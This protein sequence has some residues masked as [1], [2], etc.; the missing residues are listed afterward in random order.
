MTGPPN[1]TAS[2]LQ[3][4]A[5]IGAAAGLRYVYAGNLPGRV[6]DL[7]NTHCPQ[8]REVVVERYGY[9][10]RDYNLTPSGAC[11]SCGTQIPGKWS[12]EFTEQ[13]TAF[14]IRLERGLTL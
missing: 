13:R 6:G 2:M 11:P 4:A 14:P 8:C 3:R 9:L 1:T 10:I 5:E 12:H 7:E